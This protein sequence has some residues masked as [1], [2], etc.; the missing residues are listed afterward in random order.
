MSERG[1]IARGTVL[2]DPRKAVEKLRAFQL[3]QPGLYVLEVVRAATLLGAGSVALYNDSDDLELTWS[4]A[5][6]PA[7]ALVHLLDHLFSATDRAL[8]LLAI[9]VNSAMGLDPSFVD[10]YTTA[11]DGLVDGEVARVRFLSEGAVLSEGALTV[12]PR[13]A[14]MPSPGFR[15]HVRERF[16]AAVIAEWLRREPAETALLRTRLLAP[17]VDVAREGAVLRAPA[18]APLRSVEMEAATGLRATLHLLPDVSTPGALSLCELGVL[19]ERRGLEPSER[20]AARRGRFPNAALPLHLVVDA[21]ALDTNISRAQVD[22]D[23][24]L[25]AALSRRWPASLA[26][27][28]EGA[29]AAT[30]AL[31]HDDP[32]RRA[33]EEAL[34]AL[35]LWAHGERWAEAVLRDVVDETAEA[36]GE[37]DGRAVGCLSTAPLVPTPFGARTTL[38]DVAASS[39]AWAVWSDDEGIAPELAPWLREVVWA[40]AARPVLRALL[41]ACALRNG[42]RALAEARAAMQRWKALMAH[43]PRPVRVEEKGAALLRIDLAAQGDPLGLVGELAVFS[44]DLRR[45]DRAVEAT[46][47]FEGRVF[48]R[49]SL[50]AAAVHLRA[51]VQ[52]PKL[53]ARP[54]FDGVQRDAALAEVT[55]ALR[56]RFV[57][58]VADAAARGDLDAIDARDRAALARAAW[59]EARACVEEPSRVRAELA[60]RV[61][62]SPALAATPAWETT[63]GDWASTAEVLRLASAAQRAVLTGPAGVGPRL[64]GRPVLVL[65]LAARQT[66]ATMVPEDAR[67]IDLRSFLPSSQTKE[68]GRVAE[69]HVPGSTL[70]AW[71]NLAGGGARL[72]VAPSSTSKSTLVLLHAGRMVTSRART[73]TLGPS[74]IALE[75]DALIPTDDGSGELPGTLSPEATALMARAEHALA[76]ALCEALLGD[77]GARK[78]LGWSDTPGMEQSVRRFL[79]AALARLPQGVGDDA[80]LRVRIASVPLIPQRTREGA[81]AL[82]PVAA[83]HG[84]LAR[85]GAGTAEFLVA[86][87]EGIDGEDFTPLILPTRE[88]QLAVARALEVKLVAGEKSLRAVV[89]AAA[90]RAARNT[91][92]GRDVE[93]LDDT[94]RM[95]GGL[96]LGVLDVEG[97]GKVAYALA[98]ELLAGRASVLLDD[99]VAVEDALGPLPYP[100][101]AR[102][103]LADESWFSG[104]FRALTKPGVAAVERL[105]RRAATECARSVLARAEAGEDVG[106][107]GRR[108]V[109]AWVNARGRRAKAHEELTRARLCAARIWRGPDGALRSVDDARATEKEPGVLMGWGAPWLPPREGEAADP[110]MLLLARQ[111][112]LDAVRLIAGGA[113][114]L[115]EAVR[116]TQRRRRFARGDAASVRLLDAPLAAWATAR[117]DDVMAPRAV[118]E[119]R[120][121]ARAEGAEVTVFEDGAAVARASLPCSIALDIAL[122]SAEVDAA[123]AAETL[124]AL[125]PVAPALTLAHRMLRAAVA[126]GVARAPWSDAALRW[127]LLRVDDP[128]P[129][130]LA[131][132]AFTDTARAPMSLRDMGLQASRFGVV[133]YVTRA[134]EEPVAPQ[135]P[136]RRVVV[137]RDAETALLGARHVA[138][139]H[140]DVVAEDLAAARWAR[141]A[142]HRVIA[143]PD[144]PRAV[145]HGVALTAEADG[146]EGELLLLPW[147]APDGGFAHWFVGRRALGGSHVDALW[148][149]KLAL[150]VPTLHPRRDRSGPQD[151][152]AL[153]AAREAARALVAR[154]VER[155]LSPR[156]GE[157]LASIAVHEGRSPVMRGGAA[158][159]VGAVWLTRDASAGSILVE[160][161]DARHA[162][163]AMLP[164]EGND[165]RA[166]FAAP[167][168]GHLW[169]RKGA[170][171]RREEWEPLVRRVVAWAWRRLLERWV[172][173]A[174]L[175]PTQDATLTH[176]VWASLAEQLP[177]G[178]LTDIARKATLPGSD[179]RVSLVTQFVKQGKQIDVAEVGSF[180][181]KH[182]V[183]RSDAR[184]FTLLAEAGALREKPVAPAPSPAPAKVPAKAA[185][186]EAPAAVPAT[187]PQARTVTERVGERALARLHAL[188]IP[189]DAVR[190]VRVLDAHAGGRGLGY[191]AADKSVWIAGDTALGRWA[192]RDLDAAEDVLVMALLAEVNR[193]LEDVTDAHEEEAI[194]ALIAQRAKGM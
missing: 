39:G 70:Y 134:P 102:V 20:A 97:D 92:R 87:P 52:S 56:A 19:L 10:V 178:A 192:I 44:A 79:L 40:P 156:G 117:L 30:V 7:D 109:C 121:A 95:G 98:P 12:I 74:V 67:W 53:S 169:L 145:L 119:V 133:A 37:V 14:G 175:D 51:A 62:E 75:D 182:A 138:V 24:G 38:R 167:I 80:A 64:D 28:V 88:L 4:G 193:A 142:A 183:P 180:R 163:E 21:D 146:F 166:V 139:D 110:P 159:A 50:G 94:L 186:R 116:A 157:A 100:L 13:P 128:T 23:R 155:A 89:D 82:R 153:R 127:H 118:G 185:V 73:E 179:V 160:A 173:R 154:A 122:A 68:P 136:G 151:D 61:A 59:V 130:E 41:S 96:L 149:A 191:R 29:L 43:P 190:A 158:G 83:L 120:L 107:I 125:D 148:P 46:I 58:A 26:A 126:Q 9:A 91:L 66:L 36:L 171:H 48:A 103:A 18:L 60:R 143:V 27:L 47:F 114:D 170:G 49:E 78:A 162:V 31:A 105:V 71:W 165:K 33:G 140:R 8:R 147:D 115:A 187:P 189:R 54:A 188:G 15:L 144:A 16:G 1:V 42:A 132:G 5:A 76:A 99:V 113:R 84:E 90:R 25:G 77:R 32:A 131:L 174:T 69:A 106:A 104:D 108:V 161:G 129:E 3:A 72:S 34:L 81:V 17:R 184:W 85:R 57:G 101:V 172:E 111:D 141:A 93:R 194:R 86:S 164:V 150:E 168:G 181:P 65:D 123:R 137:L 45:E 176:L 152:D 35:V 55:R 6:P 177:G 135:E 22:L 2:V 112:E 63:H 11:H 124:A